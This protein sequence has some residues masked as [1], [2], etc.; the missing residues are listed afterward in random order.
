MLNAEFA[1]LHACATYVVVADNPHPA[2]GEGVSKCL[3][4]AFA[5]KSYKSVQI[6]QMDFHHFDVERFG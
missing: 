3:E 5:Q 2:Y 1:I 6:Q 4:C